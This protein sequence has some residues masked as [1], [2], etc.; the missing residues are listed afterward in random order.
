METTSPP[1]PL[2]VDA[3][4]QLEGRELDRAVQ[5][6]LTGSPVT[7]NSWGLLECRSVEGYRIRLPQYHYSWEAAMSL[8][9]Q[10]KEMGSDQQI[11]FIENTLECLIERTSGDYG[12]NLLL[13]FEL[14]DYA[15]AYIITC[16]DGE[17]AQTIGE[18]E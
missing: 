10:V 4:M 14:V 9:D 17:G 5:E 16:P 15:R 2:T 7:P 6:R 18:V 3:V 13:Y 1:T 11:A 12:M 8:R